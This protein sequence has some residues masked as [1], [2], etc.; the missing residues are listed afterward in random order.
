MRGCQQ[1]HTHIL[2]SGILFR[3]E[4]M[5]LPVE[6]SWGSPHQYDFPGR[7]SLATSPAL[8]GILTYLQC[9]VLQPQGSLMGTGHWV[10]ICCEGLALWRAAVWGVS[11]REGGQHILLSAQKGTIGHAG[12]SFCCIKP[13]CSLGVSKGWTSRKWPKGE[14]SW[15]LQL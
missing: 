3:V 6:D 14:S 13:S 7:G 2:F 4:G 10:P 11:W 5:D 9:F 15:L 1:L 8:P 12:F